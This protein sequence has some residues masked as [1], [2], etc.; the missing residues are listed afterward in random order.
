M[1][2]A[3]IIVGATWNKEGKITFALLQSRTL[4]TSSNNDSDNGESGNDSMDQSSDT[5]SN[6]DFDPQDGRQLDR[7]AVVAETY[8]G[9]K[10]A[11]ENYFEVKESSIK[12]DLEEDINS[13]KDTEF[14][15]PEY[16]SEL[17]SS[18]DSLL[19]QLEDSKDTIRDLADIPLSDTSSSQS[20]PQDTSDIERTDFMS[21]FDE[22]DN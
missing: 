16:I 5:S 6:Q 22:E 4:L 20:F 19:A 7:S 13:V 21:S 18:A 12:S 3:A 1:I 10:D 9:D 15:T 11:L 14:D 17:R 8:S 2:L